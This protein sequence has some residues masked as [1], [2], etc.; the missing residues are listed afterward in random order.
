MNRNLENKIFW[1]VV[2]VIVIIVCLS[3]LWACGTKKTVTE[4]VIEYVH[5][6]IRTTKTDTI[7][8]VKVVTLHD[9]LKHVESHYVTLNDVGDTIK[10]VHVNNIIERTLVVDSTNRYQAK[11][12]SLQAIINKQKETKDKIVKKGII[13]PWWVW[14]VSPLILV[15]G[16]G[17]ISKKLIARKWHG[18]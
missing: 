11:V 10:E 1:I 7:R 15:L 14:I 2:E 4:T 12:D 5:D 9:T 6:T 18:T 13:V 8:D 3:A 17:I 16:L